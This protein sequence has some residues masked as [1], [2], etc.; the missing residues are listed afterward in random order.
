ME[1]VAVS[2][3]EELMEESQTVPFEPAFIATDL[4]EGIELVESKLLTL[5]K[6]SAK[7]ILDLSTFAGERPLR[8]RHASYLM[9]AMKRKTFMPELVQIITAVLKGKEYRVNGQHTCWAAYNMIPPVSFRVRMLRYKVSSEEDLR[10]LYSSVD[11]GASRTNANVLISYLAGKGE[12]AKF[13]PR[14]IRMLSEGIGFWLWEQSN[15]RRHDADDKAYLMQNKYADVTMRIGEFLSQK[16]E[17]A[18]HLKRAAVFAAMYE[19]FSAPRRDD[20][21]PEEFWGRVAD[22]LHIS[23]EREPIAKLRHYLLNTKIRD[24][25]SEIGGRKLKRDTTEKMYRKCIFA[26]NSWRRGETVKEFL[27]AP[28]GTERPAAI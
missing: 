25:V 27:K 2:K 20:K 13:Q 4:G 21:S 6:D 10:R 7:K 5:N 15:V 18:R 26:W 3:F 11:R 16:I 23:D 17:N 12:F 14:V 28:E 8:D 19:T 9:G 24:H 1:A 22:G